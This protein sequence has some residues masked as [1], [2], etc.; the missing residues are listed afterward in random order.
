M[1]TNLLSPEELAALAEG[2]TN[3]SIPVDTG[4]NMSA[5][6]KKHDLSSEDSRSEE[7]V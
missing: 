7:V 4:F 1:A 5:S 6:V 3:G 2:V